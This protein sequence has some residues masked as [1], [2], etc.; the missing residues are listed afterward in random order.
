MHNLLALLF[1]L[2]VLSSTYA[3]TADPA[4]E[5]ADVLAKKYSLDAVQAENMYT[6]QVRKQKNLTEIVGLQASDPALYHAK[7]ASVQQGTLASIRRVLTTKAQRDLFQ[8]TQS[9]QRRLRGEKRREMEAQ[10]DDPF[11]MEAAVLAIYME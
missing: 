4:R 6:V 7:L 9:E 8:Q 5:A 3:Q 1:L 2:T 11:A 10:G